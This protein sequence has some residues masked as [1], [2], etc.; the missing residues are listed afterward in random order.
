MKVLLSIKPEYAEKILLGQK[1][2]EF[3]RT[4]FKSTTVTK[5]IIYATNPIQKVIGEFEIEQVLSLKLGELWKKTM[6]ASGIEKEFYDRYF[7][8]KKI[9][10]AI[11]IKKA[12]R[13]S[14][15]LDL[16]DL[17][18]KQAPQSFMYLHTEPQIEWHQE[19]HRSVT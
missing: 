9:G 12:K 1:K 15:Y 16:G 19:T 10:H 5:V 7:S 6:H 2:Y 17:N 18:V 14:N 4:L 11:M 3:R 8:G 13:Y